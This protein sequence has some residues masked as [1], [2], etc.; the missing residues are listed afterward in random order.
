MRG[1]HLPRRHK[2]QS[3]RNMSGLRSLKWE[4][5]TPRSNGPLSPSE[6]SSHGRWSWVQKFF[7]SRQV[8]RLQCTITTAKCLAFILLIPETK[9]L[10]GHQPL[11]SWISYSVVH[12]ASTDNFLVTM[13]LDKTGKIKVIFHKTELCKIR[14]QSSSS[15]CTSSLICEIHSSI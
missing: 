3:R 10:Y 2:T 14:E 4:S 1:Q 11:S 6:C 13:P 8:S 9:Y 12:T 5:D 7:L 15:L